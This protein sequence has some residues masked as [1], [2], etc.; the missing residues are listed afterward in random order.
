MEI[1]NLIRN[2]RIENGITQKDLYH[3]LCSR[4]VYLQLEDGKVIVEELLSER[5]FSRLHVQYRLVDIMLG[6]EAFWQKE[7]RYEIN[8]QIRKQCWEKAEILLKEYMEK[9]PKT[10]LHQQ[11]ILAKQAELLFRKEKDN[12]ED[13]SGI[14]KLFLEALELT[15]SVSELEN[16]LKK[17]GVISEEELWLYLHYRNCCLEFSTEEYLFFLKKIEQIFL[18][19]QIYVEVYFETGY[20]F[21]LTLFEQEH[22]VLCRTICQKAI[23]ELKSGTKKFHLAEFYF[24]D[25]I[26]GMRLKQGVQEKKKLFQQCKMAYY[27]S[28]CFGEKEIAKKMEE[29]CRKEYKWHITG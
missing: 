10:A 8:L 28:F 12:K 6:D 1:S 5:L 27:S 18:S 13:R 19:V 25:A 14:G 15:M 29:Y 26:A 4:K 3:G 22:Y 7:C 9:A 16:Q 20:R 2:L 21:A 24:L 17:D 23:E 11:F